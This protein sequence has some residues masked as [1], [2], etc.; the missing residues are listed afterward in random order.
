MRGPIGRTRGRHAERGQ[1][2]IIVAGGLVVLLGM[3]SLAVD[4]GYWRNQQRQEQSAADS[5][6]IAGT[7]AT[8]YT[9]TA[10]TPAPSEVKAAA[11]LAATKNGYTADGGATTSVTVRSPPLAGT[12]TNDSS[13]VEVTI[14]KKQPLFFAGIFGVKAPDVSAR[15]VARHVADI[16]PACIVQLDQSAGIRLAANSV[17]AVNCS[18]A[19][20]YPPSGKNCLT[21]A[22][23]VYFS[24]TFGNTPPNVCANTNPPPINTPS[25]TAVADP[26][27]V[28]SGCSYLMKST[29]PTSG[30]S[31]LNGISSAT[32]LSAGVYYVYGDITASVT[33][34][35]VTIVHVTGAIAI[36]KN[37][38]G[39]AFSITAPSIG[40][41]AGVAYYQ[42]PSNSS[43]ITFGGAS[44]TWLGLF[45]APAAV[46]TNNGTDTF[47]SIVVGSYRLNTDLIVDPSK[48]PAAVRAAQGTT[49]AA[50]AE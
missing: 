33:G 37:K 46:N 2:L 24:G 49:H 15:A 36:K 28:I 48:A 18:I 23:S 19:L 8:Y 3:L 38:N 43:P 44:S 29:F 10:A 1:V 11:T 35:D 26:C 41:T 40:P 20:N 7:I 13:A 22:G 16:K 27:F 47:S 50:L 9:T 45:Y 12:Y 21:A 4:L 25:A 39:A 34:L 17:D 6:A 30:P 32:V 5:A 31:V 14:V 42:P